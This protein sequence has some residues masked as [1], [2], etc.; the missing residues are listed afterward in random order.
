ML[1]TGSAGGTAEYHPCP[2]LFVQVETDEG[3]WLGK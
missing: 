3:L 2:E 1:A